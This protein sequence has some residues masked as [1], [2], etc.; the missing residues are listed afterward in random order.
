MHS[1][2][3]NSAQLGMTKNPVRRRLR[4]WQAATCASSY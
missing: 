1:L 3:Y 4:I 2:V